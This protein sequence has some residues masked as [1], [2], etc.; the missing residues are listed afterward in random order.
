MVDSLERPRA[1]LEEHQAPLPDALRQEYGGDD[2]LLQDD[3]RRDTKL[4]LFLNNTAA[5]P[6]YVRGWSNFVVG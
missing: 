2:R 6:D 4:R 1:C 3:V 5:R